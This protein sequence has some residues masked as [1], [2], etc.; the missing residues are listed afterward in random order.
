M[1]FAILYCM[2]KIFACFF[3]KKFKCMALSQRGRPYK[4]ISTSHRYQEKAVF[5][6]GPLTTFTLEGG[7]LVAFVPLLLVT[8][9]QA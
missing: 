3:L 2:L 1:G 5:S 8:E 9:K 6:Q 4:S 7:I